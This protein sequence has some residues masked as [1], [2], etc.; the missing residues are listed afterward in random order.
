MLSAVVVSKRRTTN[1]R[2]LLFAVS[3]RGAE[4]HFLLFCAKV[5]GKGRGGT[6]FSKKVPPHSLLFFPRSFLPTLVAHSDV[7]VVAADEDLATDG[8]DV[9]ILID[10]GVHGCFIAARADGLD[11]GNGVGDL[12]EA[13]ATGEEVCQKVGTQTKAHNG[14]IVYVNDFA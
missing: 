12:K 8:N 10:A 1:G 6:L 5:F 13:A 9:S 2:S 7:G 3:V 14:N 4:I 11:L